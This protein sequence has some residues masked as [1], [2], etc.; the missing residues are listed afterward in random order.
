MFNNIVIV[1]KNAAGVV[2]QRIKVPITYAPRSKTLARLEGDPNLDRPDAVTLPR[3][4]FEITSMNYAGDRKGVSTDRILARD[5]NDN[6]KNRSVFRGVPYDIGYQL[7]VFTKNFEDACQIAEQIL[8]FFT[9]AWTVSMRHVDAV[10]VTIDVPIVLV[11][12]SFSDEYEGNFEERRAIIWTFDFILKGHFFGPVTNKGVIKF[13]NADVVA[14][15]NET[16]D[17]QITVQPGL[18]ANGQPTTDINNTVP[19]A[20]IEES[21][22]W[23][24]IVRRIDP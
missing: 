22:N 9:P 1:R 19:Y 10:D 2:Q 17:R 16:V 23:D 8:P 6:N 5:P 11:G 24:Y 12:T 7:N 3:M 20:S 14:N 18:T 15:D 13:V 21:D 4:S